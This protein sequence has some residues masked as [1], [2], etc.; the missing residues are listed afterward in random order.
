MKN[1]SGYCHINPSESKNVKDYIVDPYDYESTSKR[2]LTST[3][4]YVALN[5]GTEPPF[6][7]EYYN[8]FKK[9]I[10]V[11]ITTG[12]PLFFSNDKFDSGCGWPSFAKP[13]DPLVINYKNDTSLGMLR[14]E[15]RSRQGDI[16]LGHV[17]NDGPK[18]LGGKR[19]CI[20]SASLH[21]IPIEKMKEEGYEKYIPF[22]K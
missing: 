9:G 8:N 11:D 21:F 22:V 12:E 7:N 18:E 3:Q 5:N 13:A 14:T 6:N 16:H 20:N 1:P 17:F 15:V 10:Y 19:Y 4:S 2:E